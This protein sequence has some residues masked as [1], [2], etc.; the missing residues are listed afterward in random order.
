MAKQVY[1][2]GQIL[3]AAQMT[4]LQANDYNQTVSA[5]TANYV[6]VA[7]DAGTRITMNSASATTVTVNTSIFAAGDTLE[8]TNIGAGVLTV[9][10]GTATVSTSSTLALKQFDSGQ[11]Y[12]TSAGVAIFFATDAADSPL[13]TKGD[14]FTFSTTNDR[15]AVGANGDTIVADSSTSTGLRYTAG[16]V[17]ANPFLN[18]AMQNWQR[19]TSV[20]LSASNTLYT[21]D[22]W[23]IQS[24]ANQALTVTRQATSDTTNLPFIQ[25]C[26]RLQRNLGQIGVNAILQTQSFETINSIPFAGK[27]VTVSY[28][29]RA[30]ANYSASGS[31]L[32]SNLVY[33]T[34]TDQNVTGTY[35]GFAVAG[36]A[37][38]TLTTTWQRFSYQATIPATAT[39]IGLYNQFTPTGSAGANDYFE[40][41][42]FQIDIG[43]VTL[44]FRT[45]AGTIQGELAACQRYYYRLGTGSGQPLGLCQGETTNIPLAV[46]VLPVSM[47]TAPT[48]D[49]ATGTNYYIV[50]TANA[51][52]NFN[53]FT[54][55]SSSTTAAVFYSTGTIASGAGGRFTTNNASSYVGFSAEL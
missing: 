25:F 49:Q 1:T 2:T 54:L 20:S 11:L 38:A 19:G 43:S 8:I 50:R 51:N 29:A 7:A 12:F 6:L 18:S 23:C 31:A 21:A 35:T 45:Y 33:G 22:R 44:P 9:T 47:R 42:G 40:S 24:Q 32:A 3:T 30:G 53:S 13:T 14:L 46:A 41:T 10:A 48:L 37:T 52:N 28:F 16:T 26:M 17:Q 5:K 15:L 39:E 36:S 55:E 4:T 34:G 27:I